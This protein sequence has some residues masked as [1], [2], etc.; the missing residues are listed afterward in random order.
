MFYLHFWQLHMD[1]K[2]SNAYLL[3][4]KSLKVLNGFFDLSDKTKLWYLYAL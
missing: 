1:D 3:N 4:H 2:S